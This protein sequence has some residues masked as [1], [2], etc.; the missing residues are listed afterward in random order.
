MI[1]DCLLFLLTPVH[2]Q[3]W[4]SKHCSAQNMQSSVVS[5]AAQKQKALVQ[6][7]VRA[8][9]FTPRLIR[10]MSQ[11]PTSLCPS[12]FRYYIRSMKMM[13]S[14]DLIIDLSIQDW[15]GVLNTDH[16]SA[17]AEQF[18]EI[19]QRMINFHAPQREV[20]LKPADSSPWLSDEIR[21]RMHRRNL[22]KIRAQRTGHDLHWDFHR[23]LRNS[24]TSDVRNAK[25]SYYGDRFSLAFSGREKWK[26]LN[27]LLGQVNN[28]AP[29]ADKLD[30]FFAAYLYCLS[31]HD[32]HF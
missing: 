18:S 10:T 24:I 29:S 3:Y 25:K 12:Q 17:A 11:D 5:T 7:L 8:S 21:G 4:R 28:L 6:F 20:Q 22:W 31:R 15:S 23:G 14:E 27:E 1:S 19:M 16:A 32:Q 2:L 9:H 26:V 13:S 30:T